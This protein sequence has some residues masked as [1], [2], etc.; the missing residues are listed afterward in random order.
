MAYIDMVSKNAKNMVS[1]LLYDCA[2]PNILNS[3][4]NAPIVSAAIA[5]RGDIVKLLLDECA[6]VK[7][8]YKR[9]D[10]LKADELLDKFGLSRYKP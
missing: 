6:D 7:Y 9:F 3:E 1:L 10:K 8:L 5:N 4:G 2:N